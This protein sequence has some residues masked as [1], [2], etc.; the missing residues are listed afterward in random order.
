MLT[1]LGDVV[2]TTRIVVLKE[3]PF[4]IED[5]MLRPTCPE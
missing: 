2:D 1:Q 3:L 5:D 4:N